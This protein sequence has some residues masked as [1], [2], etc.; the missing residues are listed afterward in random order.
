MTETSQLNP[1]F[2]GSTK[3][4]FGVIVFLYLNNQYPISFHL[5]WLLKCYKL[6]LSKHK[7]S[8]L[9]IWS[10]LAIC[11]VQAHIYGTLC[12]TENEQNT[13]QAQP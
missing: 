13:E 2:R 12:K 11:S 8:F 5:V 9:L 7:G 10:L 4:N 3:N 6:L 1:D